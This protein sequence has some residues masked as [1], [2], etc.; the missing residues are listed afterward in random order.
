MGSYLD[1]WFDML[2]VRSRRHEE[3]M[4]LAKNVLIPV[5]NARTDLSHPCEIMGDLQF[6]RRYRGSIDNLN[7]IFVGDVT[8]LCNSWFEAAVKFPI[9]ITQIAPSQYLADKAM[10]ENLNKCA[11][12]K[13]LLSDSMEAINGNID[14]IYTDCWPKS[15]DKKTAEEIRNSFLPY[16]IKI[17]HL[18]R[19]EKSPD[20]LRKMFLPCPPVTR[21]EEV[22][23]DA[24]NSK[25]CLNY[26]AKKYLLHSQNAI[27]E[28]LLT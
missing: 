8:N 18:K 23:N 14:L 4:Y 13:I 28:M 9:T 1:N 22:S 24:M 7:M 15:G 27:M 19:L 5:I 3:L 11:E 12:G 21:G 6:I 26:Q 17:E 10:V 2:I 25:I 20:V 16:Q